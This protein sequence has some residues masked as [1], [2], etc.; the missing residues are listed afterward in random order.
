MEATK[1][2]LR[3]PNFGDN[4]HSPGYE[5]ISPIRP[6][7][8]FL[9]DKVIQ[10]KSLLSYF[11]HVESIKNL[12]GVFEILSIPWPSM[13]TNLHSIKPSKM[14]KLHW[15]RRQQKTLIVD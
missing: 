4:F 10:L 14:A 6:N 5:T 8:K 2:T 12:K 1:I 3:S 11:L 15:V 13:L 7:K 9:E